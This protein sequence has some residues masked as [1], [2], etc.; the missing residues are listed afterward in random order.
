MSTPDTLNAG[1]QDALADEWA[2]AL[3]EAK[4]T[5]VTAPPPAPTIE[6]IILSFL[7]S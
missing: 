1:E 2:A 6:L 7:R 4:P 5:V 3:A